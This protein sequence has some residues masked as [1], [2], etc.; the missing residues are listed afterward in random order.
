MR[1]SSSGHNGFPAM[2]PPTLRRLLPNLGWDINKSLISSTLF[3][4]EFS[5]KAM[6]L[7][8]SRLSFPA[9]DAQNSSTFGT[10]SDIFSR[11]QLKASKNSIT[12]AFE[13]TPAIM[14]PRDFHS[15]IF[16]IS[17]PTLCVADPV[18][19]HLRK[20]L[21][22]SITCRSQSR[23][24]YPLVKAKSRTTHLPSSPER[25]ISAL[26]PSSANAE[27]GSIAYPSL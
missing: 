21:P 20:N 4:T 8:E 1:S 13:D 10:H 27:R 12:D 14:H 2:Y 11:S 9:N 5:E 23:Q 25:A 18:E 24:I 7:P 16:V 17:F 15:F 22:G 19:L 3:S 6:R 26:N